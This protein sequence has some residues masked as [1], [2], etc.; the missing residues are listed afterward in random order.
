MT[1]V[2]NSTKEKNSP[3]STLALAVTAPL[4]S[5]WTGSGLSRSK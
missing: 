3:L 5:V 1:L 2:W 4:S